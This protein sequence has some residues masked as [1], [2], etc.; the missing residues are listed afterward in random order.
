MTLVRTSPVAAT[1][2]RRF[3]GNAGRRLRVDPSLAI[4]VVVFLAALLAD[5]VLIAR[6]APSMAELVSL[7][8]A[9][10]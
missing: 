9:T 6:V 5:A 2:F 7:Y 10:T 3:G 1:P 4:A 8:A